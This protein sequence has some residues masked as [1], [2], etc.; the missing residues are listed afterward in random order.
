LGTVNRVIWRFAIEYRSLWD[1][2]VLVRWTM[3]ALDTVILVVILLCF[4]LLRVAR[5][6]IA[7]RHNSPTPN[8]QP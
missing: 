3:V 5:Q 6:H 2:D 4:V 7:D 8:S 1:E